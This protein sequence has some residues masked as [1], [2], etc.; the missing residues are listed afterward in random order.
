[1]QLAKQALSVPIRLA[2]MQAASLMLTYVLFDFAVLSQDIH[3]PNELYVHSL[4]L[5]GSL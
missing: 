5:D 2:W 3:H 4:E 1:M